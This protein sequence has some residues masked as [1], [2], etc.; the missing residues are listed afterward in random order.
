M[1][2]AIPNVLQVRIPRDLSAY[3]LVDSGDG[4]KLEGWGEFRLARP[5]GQVVW[6]RRYPSEWERV[7]ASFL[8]A[9][10]EGAWKIRQAALRERFAW[11]HGRLRFWLELTPFKHTGVFPEQ[12]INWAWL[13][14]IVARLKRRGGPVSVLN[15]F[16]YTGGATLACAA[17]GADE[18]VHCDASKPA[19]AWAK[20]N[21]EL[22]GLAEA[23]VRFIL[24]DAVKFIER[25]IRRGRRYQ[26]IILDPPVYG[27]GPKG[28]KWE[29]EKDLARL[30]S[31]LGDLLDPERGFVLLNAYTTGLSALG[32]GNLFEAAFGARGDLEIGEIA[33]PHA[34]DARVLPAGIFAQW[35]YGC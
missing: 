5:D 29:I 15:T 8:R 26:G 28:E 35:S 25:E 32:L 24:D 11:Q 6:P 3:A 4:M 17:A 19:L 23:R 7:D 13:A 33:L 31:K 16:A 30:F 34:R 10:R 18:T 22:S 9:G 27:R 21:L 2:Q 20:A 14:E 12:A 1:T